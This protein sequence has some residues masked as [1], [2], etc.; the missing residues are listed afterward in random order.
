M[1]LDE[2]QLTG[3]LLLLAQTEGTELNCDECLAMTAAYAE[4]ELTGKTP[5]EAHEKVRQHLAICPDCK[6]E[7][8]AL[9][10]AIDGLTS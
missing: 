8:L 4:H 2:Q 10:H 1:K 9:L 7:Y 6:E 5:Q 3:L